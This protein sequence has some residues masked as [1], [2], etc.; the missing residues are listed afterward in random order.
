MRNL[1]AVLLLTAFSTTVAHG[2]FYS[3]PEDFSGFNTGDALTG[4]TKGTWTSVNAIITNQS[5]Y[6]S[7][8]AAYF[9][10]G[11]SATNTIDVN[12]P[13]PS[14]VW[15]DFRIKPALGVQ[16]G[17]E[18]PTGV[19]TL[20]FF[21][22][23][24]YIQYRQGTA[25]ITASNNIFGGAVG[26]V[27]D[28]AWQR[29]SVF[30][31]YT[32]KTFAIVL[33]DVVIA[34]DIPFVNTGSKYL[35]FTLNNQD[36]SA[37][38]DNIRI[39]NSL[40]SE[41]NASSNH[42]ETADAGELDEYGYVARTLT[43]DTAYTGLAE[44]KFSEL[45]AALAAY[46]ANDVITVANGA[47]GAITVSN[48]VTI[49]GTFT[50]A[51]I[52]V[53]NGATLTLSSAVEVDN[54]VTVAAGS[55]LVA[56][57]TLTVAGALGVTGTLTLGANASA[58]TAA[59]AGTVNI[60]NHTL[61]VDGLANLTGSG[62]IQI[63][64]NGTLDTNGSITMGSGTR[65]VS[66]G[67]LL[68]NTLLVMN[69]E[70]TING[71]DWGVGQREKSLPFDDDFE[72]YAV[73]QAVTNLGAFGWSASANSVVVQG[74]EV[75]PGIGSTKSVILPDGT[76]LTLKIDGEDQ[77]R[78]WTDFYI[79]PALGVEPGDASSTADKGF[80]S[81]VDNDG[82]LNAATIENGTETNWVALGKKASW[83]GSE[84]VFN[85]DFTNQF[86]NGSFT[87][88]SVFQDYEKSTF[89]VFVGT[90]NLVAIAK[91]FPGAHTE[92]STFVVAN[93]GD[94]AFLDDMRVLASPPFSP[95]DPTVDINVNGMDDREEIHW[96]GD[97][98]TYGDIR[99][100]LFRFM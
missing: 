74:D 29:I 90:T 91:A 10:E 56:S 16:P 13:T 46:R 1:T 37:L 84:P 85:V 93:A 100:S 95:G 47:Y 65:I 63:G 45:S 59:V 52:T 97:L 24:G 60:G 58:G 71:A 26:V 99:G 39:Y 27:T 78:I 49:S 30:Q 5:A 3:T 54:A 22:T 34:Q 25:W 76:E 87:R 11:S 17:G 55:S 89:S 57:G 64:A 94:N 83:S 43:V 40:P 77:K 81:F 72:L 23:D 14:R 79:R 38:L 41:L 32:A 75:A 50:V 70:F 42:I 44:P 33:N 67:G 86:N 31:D 96:F 35:Q 61:T 48:T 4:G 98:S 6:S 53:T 7:P 36:N 2:A 8:N 92:Y 15:T 20:F 66:A 28:D 69:G 80:S 88:V 19:Q 12:N 21:D 82:N 62:S 68:E 73:N 9:G 18:I 51:S